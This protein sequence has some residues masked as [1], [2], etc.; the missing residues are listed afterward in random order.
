MTAGGATTLLL[1]RHAHTEW[2]G[3]GLSGRRRGIHLSANGRAQARSLA[4]RLA[5]IPIA[6]IYSSPLERAMETA[7]ALG[8]AVTARAGLDEVDF[9]EWTGRTFDELRDDAG[10]Q[11]W[12]AVRSRGVAPGGERMSDVQARVVGELDNACASHRGGIVAVVSHADVLRAAL[13]HYLGMSLD[14]FWR[15][16]IAPASVSVVSLGDDGPRVLRM[17][18]DGPLAMARA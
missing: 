5:G 10:W 13:L 4:G 14:L 8:G 6:A 16:D 15:L 2:V 18:D 11:Q 7:A 12:N 17:N 9:G 3:H 1:V